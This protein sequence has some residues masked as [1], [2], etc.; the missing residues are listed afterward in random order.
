MFQNY[1]D[2]TEKLPMEAY[3][4]LEELDPH[5]KLHLLSTSLPPL[6]PHFFVPPLTEKPQNPIMDTLKQEMEY[7]NRK[8]FPSLPPE[9]NLLTVD[10][11]VE[12]H[13]NTGHNLWAEDEARHPDDYPQFDP[14]PVVL[15]SNIY[16]HLEGHIE[17]HSPHTV[18]AIFAY[19]LTHV[20]HDY[21]EQVSRS[22][23]YGADLVKKASRDTGK[24][25]DQY[26]SDE[27]EDEDEDE[28]EDFSDA[29]QP[30]VAIF[31]SF[32][33]TK[34]IEAMPAARKSLVLLQKAQPD[35][36]ILQR[37]IAKGVIRWFWTEAAIVAAWNGK[38]FDD[39][40]QGN[41]E[42]QDIPSVPTDEGNLGI[43][44]LFDLE[45]G[46]NLCASTTVTQGVA[47][48]RSLQRFIDEFPVALPSM[49]P[50]LTQLT[51]LVLAPLIHHA[52]SLSTALLTLFLAPPTTA[53][54]TLSFQA[55]LHLLRSYL[56]LSAPPF[57]SRLAA[58]LF[59]H[60]EG[61]EAEH[62]PHSIS[63]RSLRRK[64]A[65][66]AL[67]GI[68]LVQPW[69]VGISPSLLERETWP[70]VGSDLSFF[71]RTV[72]VDSS[73]EIGRY[74]S[75]PGTDSGG[76]RIEDKS[77]VLKEAEYRLGFAIRELPVGSLRD[78]WLNPLSELHRL[79]LLI[80]PLIRIPSY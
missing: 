32:F 5:D 79:S 61:P 55:H 33:P 50:T 64:T 35:H 45:P 30:L 48:T 46:A 74:V 77:R 66:K 69:A 31:P 71:L 23:G 11:T 51:S 4:P 63:F 22:V 1:L 9:L 17:R 18:T 24:K 38:Y 58:A 62:T 73:L 42:T 80:L 59:S 56:L 13:S 26:S 8:P 44:K 75:S 43:F 27:E 36:P 28:D 16:T 70:P 78:K 6:V 47:A 72:I 40:E 10:Q 19:I 34:L 54:D 3:V 60:Q 2:T 68:D 53:D 21:L 39:K 57:K 12:P 49:T 20:S 15:L 37:T 7:K 41:Q 25:L 29:E 14:S 52:S 76:D 67:D 65:K